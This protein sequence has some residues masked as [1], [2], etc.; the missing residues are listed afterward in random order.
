MIGIEIK[1]GFMDF[2]KTDFQCPNCEKWYDDI[3]DKYLNRCNR[4][5]SWA[6]KIKCGCGNHFYMTYNYMGDAVSFC[7]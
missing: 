3:N 5:K 2:A 6:T 7:L 1:D 4:N